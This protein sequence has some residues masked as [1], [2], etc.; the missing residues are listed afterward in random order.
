[1]P[2][3]NHYPRHIALGISALALFLTVAA[4]ISAGRGDLR[5][6]PVVVDLVLLCSAVFAVLGWRREK[7]WMTFAACCGLLLTAFGGS[8]LFA[9]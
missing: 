7:A 8:L 4:L 3:G 5:P 9:E 6:G 2:T 1:M